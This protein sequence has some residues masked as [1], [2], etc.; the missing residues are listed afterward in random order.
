MMAEQENS[1][2]ESNIRRLDPHIRVI[3]DHATQV[4]VYSYEEDT[5]VS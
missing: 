4:A 3:V 1:L 5:W 2:N